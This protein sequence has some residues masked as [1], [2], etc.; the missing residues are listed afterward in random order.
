MPDKDAAV[1]M[2]KSKCVPI[3]VKEKRPLLKVEIVL[4]FPASGDV[5]ICIG[6]KYCWEGHKTTNN[7]NQEFTTHMFQFNWKHSRSIIID[8]RICFENILF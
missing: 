1:P 5:Y 3:V 6:N 7:I 4:A 2:M 8:L